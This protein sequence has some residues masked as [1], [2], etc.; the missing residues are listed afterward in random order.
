M[1]GMLLNAFTDCYY[2]CLLTTLQWHHGF[3]QHF[4]LYEWR[5][6]GT[7]SGPS[8]PT[9]GSSLQLRQGSKALVSLHAAWPKK[10]REI[11]QF[12]Q[13]E[14]A[15]QGGR[16]GGGA[17]SGSA[18]AN[19][20]TGLQATGVGGGSRNEDGRAAVQVLGAAR[21]EQQKLQEARTVDAAAGQANQ[22]VGREVEEP[23]LGG[24][25]RV[26]DAV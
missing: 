3:N 9:D 5:P 16:G 22:L 24:G 7:N 25:G 21:E 19:D 8:R 26:S 18:A 10:W 14:F 15:G 4:G 17:A 1:I 11:V 20:A 13:Q 2:Q 23:L 12:A 6:P